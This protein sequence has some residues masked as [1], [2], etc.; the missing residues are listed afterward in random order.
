MTIRRPGNEELER[1]I[2]NT[3]GIALV[4]LL[5]AGVAACF[6]TRSFVQTFHSVSHSHDILVQLEQTLI[7]T[8]NIETGTRGYVITGDPTFLDPVG[9]GRIQV[10]KSL[11]RLRDLLADNA[12]QRQRFERLQPMVDRKIALMSERI[13]LRWEMGFDVA[14]HSAAQREAKQTMDQ[15]RSIIGEMEATERGM[16][17]QRTAAAQSV[18]QTSVRIII[19]TT[20]LA[21]GIVAV[22]AW[23]VRRDFTRR[24]E[25]EAE[26][27]RFFVLSLDLLCIAGHD[28]NF[29]RLNPAWENVLGF[30]TEELMSCPSIDFVHPDDRERTRQAGEQI[31]S[32]QPIL[33][34]ENRYRCRDG[35]YRWLLWSATPLTE[36][37]L[38][39]AAAR[40]I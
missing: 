23:Q 13:E 19:F 36:K 6:S 3:F 32:G 11:A 10:K 16:L 40:D 15:I 21:I 1:K 20:V 34:F 27:D 37:K 22:S 26:R 35:S 28:G 14:A 25:A 2:Q 17:S 29:K 31:R 4:F 24:C 8:L 39:Y 38:T 9:P 33:S 12:L 7:A 5:T 18:A 30:S